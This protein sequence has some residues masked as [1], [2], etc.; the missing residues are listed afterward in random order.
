MNLTAKLTPQ[1]V[2]EALDAGRRAVEQAF[3]NLPEHLS[4]VLGYAVDVI[5]EDRDNDGVKELHVRPAEIS[6]VGYGRAID[7]HHNQVAEYRQ[8]VA[9]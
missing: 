1:D 8:I 7:L 9:A 6:T 3:Q 2:R 5:L 4:P